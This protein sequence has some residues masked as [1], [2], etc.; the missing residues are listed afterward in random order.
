MLRLLILLY[1]CLVATSVSFAQ[2]LHLP[3]DG[4]WF[5]VQGG[6]TPNVNNHMALKP[7]WF[8]IDFAKVGGQSN[9]ELS[10]ADASRLEHHYSWGEP[11]FAPH[12][13]RVLTV[14]KDLPDNPLGRKDIH[15]PAGNYLTIQIAPERFLFLAHFQCGTITVEPGDLVRRGQFLG[16]C[17]NSG[18]SDF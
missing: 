1:C 2:V 17:G 15:N 8:G 16:N 9:R 7:Q 18:N 12:E 14:R 10:L 6:D 4:R 11:I 13:G 3:F 5:V